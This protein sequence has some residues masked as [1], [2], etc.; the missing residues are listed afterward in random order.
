MSKK[1]I[2]IGFGLI[3]VAAVLGL[4][5]CESIGFY[6]QVVK[7]HSQIMIKREPIARVVEKESTGKELRRKLSIIKH[8]RLFAIETLQL[9]DNGSYTQYVDTG[10]PYVVWNVIATKP[11]S[12][13]PIEH[14]FPVAGC[15]SYRGYFKKAAAE[16]YAGKLKVKGYDVI[17]SG[18]SAYSTLGWFSDPV[19]NT[20][21][22]RSD[23]GLAGLVFHELS[24]QQV[25]KAGDTAFNESFATAVELAGVRAWVASQKNVLG[26]KGKDQPLSEIKQQDLASYKVV[27]SKS[28]EVVRLILKQR[29]KIG[30]AYRKI[31]PADTKSLAELKR[32]GFAELRDAYKKLR[33]KG[34]GSK[35]FDRWFAG[36]LNNASLV[37]FGDYHGWVSAFDALLKQANGD[38]VKFYE[39]VEALAALDKAM[40]RKKLLALQAIPKAQGETQ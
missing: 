11:Y 10:R 15:V 1:A 22:N 32:Q 4:S 2:K 28:A 18:A 34:G 6:S 36:T 25:Y 23:L 24:H 19:L 7:G 27:K 20:M 40:R 29:N 38:W 26:N 35:G 33:A 17:I 30:A 39:S 14:C 5:A 3:I 37:L 8:A 9:P 13:R 21:L 31:D 16:A 12:I